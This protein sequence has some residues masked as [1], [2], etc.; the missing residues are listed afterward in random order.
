MVE[1]N[2]TEIHILEVAPKHGSTTNPPEMETTGRMLIVDE[3]FPLFKQI[4]DPKVRQQIFNAK[5]MALIHEEFDGLFT[6][7]RMA[8]LLAEEEAKGVP[9]PTTLKAPKYKSAKDL[10][11]DIL[12]STAGFVVYSGG[13]K[14][15]DNP[16]TMDDGPQV[17]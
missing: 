17:A 8:N 14:K 9:K 7:I 13:K 16:T 10:D 15:S 1:Q 3:D 5:R 12:T 4:A 6:A 2:E 11:K